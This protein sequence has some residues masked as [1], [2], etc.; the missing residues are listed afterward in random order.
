[1]Q[2]LQA[3]RYE[4]MPT[5]EQQRQMRRFGGSCRFVFNKALALRKERH[6]Q[7]GKTLGYAGL[8]KLLTEWRNEAE[9]PWP[10]NAPTH[11]CNRC[12]KSVVCGFEENADLVG[13][14]NILRA[15]YARCACE[16]SGEVM[17]PAAGTHRSGSF[18]F[19]AGMSSVGIPQLQAGEDVKYP[20]LK[21]CTYIKPKLVYCPQIITPF[22]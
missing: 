1:M 17:P 5:G 19:D 3:F 12:S 9:T 20:S 10:A 21:H 18:R 13:A 2:R 11:H 4:L 7:G 14:I 8:C 16:V 22:C 6:E 15:G